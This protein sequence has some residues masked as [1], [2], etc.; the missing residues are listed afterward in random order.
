MTLKTVEVDADG[1]FETVI[2]DTGERLQGT[3]LGNHKVTARGSVSGDAQ[4]SF[5]QR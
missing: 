4:T 2:D 3:A 1:C 5:E